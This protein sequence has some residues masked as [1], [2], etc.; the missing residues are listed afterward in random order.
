MRCQR[1]CRQRLVKI[2]YSLVP[3]ERR[4]FTETAPI[5]EFQDKLIRAASEG[6]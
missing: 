1:A 4:V 2:D 5:A 6:T 3:I